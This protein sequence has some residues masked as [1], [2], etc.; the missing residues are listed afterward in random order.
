M[1]HLSIKDLSEEDRPREKLLH[2]GASALSNAELLAIILGSGNREQSAVDLAQ[3][4]L[5]K[6]ENNLNTFSRFNLSDL[7]Q[8]KGVGEAK[9]I[10]VLA[11]L[12]L[13]RRRKIAEKPVSKSIKSSGDIFNI[14]NDILSDINHEEFWIVLLNRSNKI[15]KKYKL[16]YGGLTG[17]VIDV[18]LIIK[19]AILQL[20]SGIILIHNHPSGNLQASESDKEITEKIKKAAKYFDINVLDHL[21]IGN[22]GYYSFADEGL[23]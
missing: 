11:T 21:I 2:N 19:E 4:M 1:K 17:T 15:I 16:S 23:V 7:I 13:G 22:N 18:R 20:S 12:E 6:S 3:E 9:A 8:F 5:N 10:S 14:F